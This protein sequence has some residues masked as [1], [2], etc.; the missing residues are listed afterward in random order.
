MLCYAIKGR[1]TNQTSVNKQHV[2]FG[3]VL[4]SLRT[5]AERERGQSLF[6]S[7]ETHET[8]VG[9]NAMQCGTSAS[10]PCHARQQTLP[11]L[12]FARPPNSESPPSS[13]WRVYLQPELYALLTNKPAA[14]SECK[15]ALL[16]FLVRKV[17][18]QRSASRPTL[19]PG[20]TT[21]R[22]RQGARSYAVAS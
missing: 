17:T 16:Y 11:H 22:I 15:R 1:V 4:P 5:H 10:A 12:S 21:S 7:K 2:T 13:L 14:L 18:V 20:D 9:T 3:A 6:S 19:P 8:S